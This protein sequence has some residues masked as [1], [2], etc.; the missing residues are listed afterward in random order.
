M[1]ESDDSSSSNSENENNENLLQESNNSGEVDN[2]LKYEERKSAQNTEEEGDKNNQKEVPENNIYDIKIIIVG[3]IGVGKTSVIR[4]YLTDKF[5]EGET[6]SIGYEMQ[7]KSIELEDETKVN[8]NIIDTAGEEKYGNLPNQYFK[9]CQGAIIMYDLTEKNSFDK[10]EH[11]LDVIKDKAVKK[12]VI[13]IAGNKSD[14]ID[15]KIN[16]E[17][18]LKPYKEKYDPQEISAKDGDNV[19]SLFQN[20]ANKIVDILKEKGENSIIKR[21]YTRTLKPNKD[22]QE[23][24]HQSTIK[25]FFSK[26]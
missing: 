22:E 1:K 13:M 23:K 15:E 17:D 18:E 6:T 25:N 7:N 14:L 10:I 8:L 24:K 11:W 5:I 20:L 2:D 26:C 16:L 12:I 19:D 21:R 4:R 9:D 3:E